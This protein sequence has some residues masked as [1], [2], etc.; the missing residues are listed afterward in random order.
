MVDPDRLS[1][2]SFA[3]ARDRI[4]LALDV[5]TLEEALSF[6]KRVQPYIGT[7]KVGLE[8]YLAE[9]PRSV[10]ALREVGLDV[11]LDLKLH[12]IPT[13]VERSAQVVGALGARYL[14]VHSLGGVAMVR[15]A[16]NGV[17]MGAQSAGCKP[18]TVVGVTVLTSDLVAAPEELARRVQIGVEGGCGALVCAGPD[19]AIVKPLA[20]GLL[21][22]VPGIRPEGS[23][24]D[25]QARMMT[26]AMALAEGADLLVIGRPITRATVPE[27]AARAIV[28]SLMNVEA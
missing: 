12:D 8:L 22:I 10:Q 26:P 20:P 17:R 18:P 25:D 21:I 14:T 2:A 15:A 7:V 24:P 3:S 11:F 9:G 16:V 23:A 27:Q 13:T 1:S 6:A 5:D 4:V 19:L 28:N